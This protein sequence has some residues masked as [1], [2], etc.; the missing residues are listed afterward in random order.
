M[1]CYVLWCDSPTQYGTYLIIDGNL[2]YQKVLPNKQIKSHHCLFFFGKKNYVLNTAEKVMPEISSL[3]EHHARKQTK[4]RDLILE[5]NNIQL[6]KQIYVIEEF[7]II[8]II[9]IISRIFKML[10]KILKYLWI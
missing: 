7:T 8:I 3:F 2:V 10:P 4:Y 6:K 1:L 5:N 9:I